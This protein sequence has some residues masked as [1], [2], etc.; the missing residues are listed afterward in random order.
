MRSKKIPPHI[1]ARKP[2]LKNDDTRGDNT[3]R[4]LRLLY[5]ILATLVSDTLRLMYGPSSPLQV[6]A[7]QSQ[8]ARHSSD[9]QYPQDSKLC[10][11]LVHPAKPFVQVPVFF[12]MF[13]A[14]I[15]F[16]SPTSTGA[17]HQ[18]TSKH[19]LEFSTGR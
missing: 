16:E 19:R 8:R 14:A 17:S 5:Q 6:H 7:M 10:S 12:L 1:F 2:I 9:R 4:Y 18:L 13:L 15:M 11:H 3:F